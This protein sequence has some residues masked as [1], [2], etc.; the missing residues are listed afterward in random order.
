MC[1][2]L[3]TFDVPA[4]LDYREVEIRCGLTG[5]SGDR[6]T[7]DSCSASPR[8]MRGI[9]QHEADIDANNAWLRSAGRGEM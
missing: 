4:G 2:N 3:V 5:P 8:T 9:D 6:V 7:C 1:N